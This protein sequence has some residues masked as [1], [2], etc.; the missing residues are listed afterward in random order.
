MQQAD[1]LQ[2]KQP[3]KTLTDMLLGWVNGTKTEEE[4]LPLELANV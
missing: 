3:L 1:A 4:E 2:Q